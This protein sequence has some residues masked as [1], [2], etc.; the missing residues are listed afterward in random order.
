MHSKVVR[1]LKPPLVVNNTN[2]V[3]SSLLDALKD[4]KEQLATLAKKVSELS[5]DDTSGQPRCYYCRQLG[6][7]AADCP[8]LKA[9][10][11]KA[12]AEKASALKDKTQN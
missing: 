2:E 8:K 3:V 6:H 4:Q 11:E 5:A 9:R 7:L 10:E 12:A 1:L